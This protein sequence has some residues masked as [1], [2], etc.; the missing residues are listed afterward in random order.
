MKQ[1]LSAIFVAVSAA[2][3]LMVSTAGIAAHKSHKAT[4]VAENYKG[5][6]NYKAE[7][8]PP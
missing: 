4:K 5:E 3:L 1:R 7:V 8:P 6:A 2:S